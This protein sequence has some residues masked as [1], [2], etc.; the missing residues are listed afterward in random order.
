MRVLAIDP[1]GSFKHGSGTSGWCVVD[2]KT[3]KIVGLGNIKAKNYESRE[4]YFNAH[5]SLINMY[6]HDILVIENFI[7]YQSTASSLYNQEL[8]TSELIG[9][10]CSLEEEQGK[11]I[12]RQKAQQ[13]KSVLKKNKVLLALVNQTEEKLTFKTTKLDRV[14][15]FFEDVRVSNHIVDA[16]RHAYY[17]LNQEKKNEI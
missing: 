12:V 5:K 6:T 14:Q 17:Y 13:I 1:S 10:I 4:K 7:L 11:K 3:G 9:V 2:D 8:E 16:I 15:W